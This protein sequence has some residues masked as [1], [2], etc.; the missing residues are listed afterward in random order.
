MLRQISKRYTKQFL[1]DITLVTLCVVLF[2][3]GF[4]LSSLSPVLLPSGGQ[5][6]SMTLEAAMPQA[7]LPEFLRPLYAALVVIRQEALQWLGRQGSI[8]VYTDPNATYNSPVV[9]EMWTVLLIVADS[10]VGI[11]IVLA[12]YQI[13]FSGFGG[14]NNYVRALE[15]LPRLVFAFIGANI[16]LLFARFW[17]DLNNIVCAILLAQ[18][19]EQPLSVLGTINLTLL[20]LPLFAL[21]LLLI[22]LLGIQMAVRLGMIVF[23][24]IWLPVLFIM[25][26]SRHTQQFAQ[27]GLRGYP[28]IVLTQMLQ[29]SCL[30][31]GVKILIP[32]LNL[33][34]GPE[35][36]IAPVA[37][38]LSGIALFWITLRIPGMLRSWALQP[39]AESGHAAFAII[40][41]TVTRLL[42]RL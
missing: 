16:S 20:I 38:I 1:P 18:V 17:I 42:F 4:C 35:A 24:T 12:G 19:Q 10:T 9:R 34:I 3:C 41:A 5:A 8:L 40:N 30:V 26:A 2:L 31:L 11:F 22:V 37:T 29:V 32:F 14:G 28:T 6:M 21:L 25:L 13:I 7:P 36:A 27:A 15:E 39:V 23:L 33:N